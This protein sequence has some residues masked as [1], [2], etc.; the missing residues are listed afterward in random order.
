MKFKVGDRIFRKETRSHFGVVTS[1]FDNLHKWYCIRWDG[2]QIDTNYMIGYVD[3][4]YDRDLKPERNRKLKD[5][6]K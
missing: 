3:R 6:L 2:D 1:V 5:L 4:T